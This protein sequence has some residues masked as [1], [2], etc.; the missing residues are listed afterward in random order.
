MQ[1]ESF[2]SVWKLRAVPDGILDEVA[3]FVML[4]CKILLV[5]IVLA[6]Q[7]V[8]CEWVFTGQIELYRTAGGRILTQVGFQS[9]H[10]GRNAGFG[11]RRIDDA[12]LR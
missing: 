12:V 3:V 2:H 9:V 7:Y 11:I 8:D 6:V 5:S 4:A 10:D 1:F